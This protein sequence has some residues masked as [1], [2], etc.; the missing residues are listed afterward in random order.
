MM[1]ES[2]IAIRQP[3]AAKD[4]L[5]TSMTPLAARAPKGMPRLA[6]DIQNAL[7]R[8]SAPNSASKEEVPPTHRLFRFLVRY[9]RP[10]GAPGRRSPI[11]HNR[12]KG[13]FQD[14]HEGG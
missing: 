2:S 11:S 7:E 5:I 1:T 10:R 8:R 6:R 3:V 9:A 14:V 12:A 13:M 4:L